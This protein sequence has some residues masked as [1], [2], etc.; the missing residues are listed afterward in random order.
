[1]MTKLQVDI[2]AQKPI[3]RGTL[4]GIQVHCKQVQGEGEVWIEGLLVGERIY[5]LSA[6][7][8]WG[9]LFND[10]EY[11]RFYESFE[12]TDAP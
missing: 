3:R 1:M 11:I 4:Q 7:R 2:V 8:P 6:V 5:I 9:D 10:E 12:V